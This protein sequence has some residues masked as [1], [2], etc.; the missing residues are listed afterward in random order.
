MVLHIYA[1]DNGALVLSSYYGKIEVVKFLVEN[2]ADIHVLDD[3]ALRMSSQNGFIEI[4]KFLINIGANIHAMNDYA[5][6]YSDCY[7]HNDVVKYLIE[8]GANIHADNDYAFRIS[9]QHGNFEL[10]K[11]LV[12]KGANIYANIDVVLKNTSILYKHDSLRFLIQLDIKFFKNNKTAIKIIKKHKLVEFYELFVID[13]EINQSKIDI[14]K[15]IDNQNIEILKKCDKFDFSSEEYLYFF[16]ALEI[17]NTEM[18]QIIF[19]KIQ[20]KNDLL[21][22]YDKISLVFDEDTKNKINRLYKNEN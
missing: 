6:R 13:E 2:G 22:V 7:E 19:N 11:L 21:N 4:V 3:Y 12:E 14:I 18:I 8:N 5:L 15:Y 10:A 17:N 20:N 16:K 1:N 9:V